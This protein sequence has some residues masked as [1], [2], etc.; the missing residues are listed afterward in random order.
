MS[1]KLFL[2]LACGLLGL[3]VAATRVASGKHD[4]QFGLW[5][6]FGVAWLVRA[7]LY[8]RESRSKGI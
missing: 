6:F 2:S 8:W 4:L 7:Y 5:L 1:G 3:A